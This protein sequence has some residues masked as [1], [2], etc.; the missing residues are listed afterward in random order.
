[1]KILLK[2]LTPRHWAWIHFKVA[3]GFVWA[4]CMIAFTPVALQSALGALIPLWMALTIAGTSVSI[5][6]L[7]M[8]VSLN[9]KIVLYGVSIELA[10]L[11]L[12]VAGPLVYFLTQ[13]TLIFTEGP[14]NRL[15]LTAFAYAMVS[16]LIYRFVVIVPRFFREARD[17]SKEV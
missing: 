15:A 11:C 12:F 10:G 14:E 1:M 17:E 6:G 2:R 3:L 8:T 13:F 4:S 16:V 7:V 5:V 9:A